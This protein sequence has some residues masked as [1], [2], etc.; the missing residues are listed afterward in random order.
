[1]KPNIILEKTDRT[2]TAQYKVDNVVLSEKDTAIQLIES[3]LNLESIKREAGGLSSLPRMKLQIL[4]IGAVSFVSLFTFGEKHLLDPERIMTILAIVKRFRPEI[5][6][7]R[8]QIYAV[9]HEGAEGIFI[10][11]E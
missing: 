6:V 2:R 10:D 9:K 11:H 5:K 4:T 7:V 8:W 3:L 1:M